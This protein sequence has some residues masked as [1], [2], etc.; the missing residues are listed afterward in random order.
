MIDAAHFETTEILKNGMTVKIRA[1]RTDDKKRVAEAFRNL[2]AESIYTRFFHA[3][4]ALTDAD[5]KAATEVDFDQVVALVVTIDESEKEVII[6]GG[7]YVTFADSSPSAV[8][9]VAFLV[10]EDYHRQGIAGRLLNHLAVIARE[11]GIKRFIAEVLPANTAMLAVF[12][13]CGFPMTKHITDGVMEVSMS[14][15]TVTVPEA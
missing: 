14:L 9:E 13:R 12:A 3:K 4:K 7:R 8:A 1:I 2:E 11:R 5:L 6:G 15:E 10:E